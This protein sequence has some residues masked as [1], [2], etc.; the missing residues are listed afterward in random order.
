MIH[1]LRYFG[2]AAAF[3]AFVFV[4]AYF[5]TS[6]SYSHLPPEQAMVKIS[7]SHAGRLVGECRKRSEVELAKIAPNMR[8]S[9]ECPRERV[10]VA[11]EFSVDGRGL[12]SATL[13]PPGLKRDG[14]ASTYRKFVLAAGR[15]RFVAR[16]RDSN[17]ADG[18][19]YHS[20]VVVDLKPRQVLV[21]DFDDNKHAFSFK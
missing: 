9:H 19:D 8:T 11:V 15:H 10:P 18:F 17:R 6:P 14:R 4:V 21:I 1:L 16:M 3:A 20:D 5:S 12:Y 7:F 2:Q 13:E